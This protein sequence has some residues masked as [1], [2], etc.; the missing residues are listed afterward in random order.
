MRKEMKSARVLKSYLDPPILWTFAPQDQLITTISHFKTP[1]LDLGYR[2]NIKYSSRLIK[3]FQIRWVT[4]FHFSVPMTNF[5]LHHQTSDT[6][7]TKSTCCD[8]YNL[9]IGARGGKAMRRAM[10]RRAGGGERGSTRIVARLQEGWEPST[11][12]LVCPTWTLQP[13]W[14]N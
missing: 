3:R 4:S 13:L 7:K 5:R 11:H 1:S 12:F 8:I 14:M 2:R 10:E 6:I 9:I